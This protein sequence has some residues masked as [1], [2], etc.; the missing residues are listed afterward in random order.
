MI[1]NFYAYEKSPFLQQSIIVL[2]RAA[3]KTL[4]V[5]AGIH[6]KILRSFSEGG[7]ASEGSARRSVWRCATAAKPWGSTGILR[8]RN[9][10][11]IIQIDAIPRLR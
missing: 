2:L 1:W 8:V 6:R 9:R 11:D 5:K 7:F 4:P 10:K 3:E